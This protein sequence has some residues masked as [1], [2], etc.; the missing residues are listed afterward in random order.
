[1]TINTAVQV[2]IKTKTE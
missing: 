1:M 2:S